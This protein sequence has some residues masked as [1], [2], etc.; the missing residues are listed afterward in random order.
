LI[1]ICD[2]GFENLTPFEQGW[3][4]GLLEGEG[5]FILRVKPGVNKPWL[6]ALIEVVNTEPNG[7]ITKRLQSLLGGK[8]YRAYRKNECKW[9]LNTKKEILCLL[10]HIKPFMS[11]LRQTKINEILTGASP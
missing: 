5:T 3:I 7:E 4:V 8:I 10:E 9:T 11:K 6:N 1:N 2:C